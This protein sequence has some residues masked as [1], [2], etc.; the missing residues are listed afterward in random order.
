[1]GGIYRQTKTQVPCFRLSFH[2]DDSQ[3]VK[4]MKKPIV[5][6]R[7]MEIRLIS[8]VVLM[9]NFGSYNNLQD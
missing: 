5:M 7:E 8:Q 6:N 3:M 1:M 4:V 9:Q 2:R